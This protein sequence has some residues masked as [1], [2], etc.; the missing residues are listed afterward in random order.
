MTFNGTAEPTLVHVQRPAGMP[1]LNNE[2][3]ATATD[4]LCVGGVRPVWWFADGEVPAALRSGTLPCTA[5]ETPTDPEPSPGTAPEQDPSST[6][7]TP[8]AASAS[9]PAAGAKPTGALASTGAGVIPVTVA[10]LLTL[11]AGGAM[12]AIRRR[13]N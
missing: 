1:N 3:F 10:A 7:A 9:A 8:P 2:G 13:V 6:T 4:A 5:P 12:L 11:T